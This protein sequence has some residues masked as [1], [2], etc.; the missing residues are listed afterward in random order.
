MTNQIV[1]I[2][3][4]GG[5]YKELIARRIRECGVLSYIVPH[6]TTIE[7]I[8]KYNPIGII[9]TG[10]PNS[11]YDSKSPKCD[12]EI[13]KLGIPVLGICYGAQLI[14]QLNGGKVIKAQVS[15]YGVTNCYIETN[16]KLFSTMDNDQKVLMSHTNHF[17]YFDM[18]QFYNFC[19]C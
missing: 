5:Q 6:T 4:F 16:N 10:G 8:K 9:F 1:L 7:E 3:D 17:F 18:Q 15:E 12:V 14:A 19:I 13:F 2:I 11:V